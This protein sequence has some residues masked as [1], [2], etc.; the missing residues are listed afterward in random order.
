MLERADEKDKRNVPI[1]FNSI[2]RTSIWH[3]RFS[4]MTKTAEW[5]RSIAPGAPLTLFMYSILAFLFGFQDAGFGSTGS[6]NGLRISMS[7]VVGIA[8][9]VSSVS[10]F[11]RG[12][13]FA[14]TFY[15]IVG[16]YW[17]SLGTI[18]L[19]IELSIFGQDESSASNALVFYFLVWTIVCAMFAWRAWQISILVTATVF[20][21][22]L[23]RV[24]LCISFLVDL[25]QGRNTALQ[26]TVG[27]IGILLGAFYFFL[28]LT[29][30][31]NHPKLEEIAVYH[32]LFKNNRDHDPVEPTHHWN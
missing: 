17:F 24:L 25:K 6:Y 26:R 10:M 7:F 3:N 27:Y 21:G 14:C 23:Q 15:G 4:A 29:V 16:A 22:T 1:D 8:I 12:N 20:V 19:V 18:R 30:L 13:T 32:V 31:Y 11:L 5:Q 2:G 9:T 28:A